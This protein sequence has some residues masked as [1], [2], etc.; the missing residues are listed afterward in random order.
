V[1]AVHH[2]AADNETVT[3]DGKSIAGAV[4]PDGEF[5]G[6]LACLYGKTWCFFALLL[7]KNLDLLIRLIDDPDYEIAGGPDISVLEIFRAPLHRYCIDDPVPCDVPQEFENTDKIGFSRCI[8]PDEDME[9]GQ[10]N[11][12][13][14]KTLEIFHVNTL[15]WHIISASHP[16]SGTKRRYWSC[17]ILK[18]GGF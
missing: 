4:K 16:H 8:G 11:I 3:G 7:L 9:P 18:N 10:P 12:K 15:N 1:I 5:I 13:F 2:L 17:R 6:G 14:G